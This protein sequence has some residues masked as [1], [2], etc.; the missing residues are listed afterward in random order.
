MKNRRINSGMRPSKTPMKIPATIPLCLIAMSSFAVAAQPPTEP[1]DALISKLI[2]LQTRNR[3]PGIAVA[4]VLEGSVKS[5]P[6]EVTHVRR[7]ITVHPVI[8]EGR[9]VRKMQCYDFHW[10]PVYGWF[11]WENRAE[12][13]GEAIW[14]WSELQGEVVVR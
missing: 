10:T 6:F 9:Q 12:A 1:S 11:L 8:E 7:V 14:I 5:G 4:M 13:G 2:N 3:T